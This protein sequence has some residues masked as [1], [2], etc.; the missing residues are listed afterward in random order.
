V[1]CGS[2]GNENPAPFRFCGRCGA[3][4]ADA[5]GP[6]SERRL[7]SVLFLDLVGFTAHAEQRDPED[8]R[9]LLEGYFATARTVIERLDGTL[10]KFIGDAVMALWGVPGAHDDDATRAVQAGLELV[11]AVQRYGPTVGIPSLSAR[12]GVATGE[13]ATTLGARDHGLVAGDIVN[14][15]SRLQA[16]AR[17]GTVLVDAATARASGRRLAF[18]AGGILSVRNRQQPVESYLAIGLG[19]DGAGGLLPEIPFVGR[20]GH[21]AALLAILEDCQ[22]SGT[23]RLATVVGGAGSGKTRLLAE[24]ERRTQGRVRWVAFRGDRHGERGPASEAAVR[25]SLAAAAGNGA[26]D[27]PMVVAIDDAQWV[28]PEAVPAILEWARSSTTPL[29]IVAAGRQEPG[30]AWGGERADLRVELKPIAAAELRGA[31]LE[32]APAIPRRLLR[33]IVDASAGLPLYA[34]EMVRMLADA[35]ILLPA[36]DRLAPGPSPPT[37]AMPESVHALLAAR[38]DGLEPAV[39][40]ALRD[41]AVLG[42]SFRDE[43]AWAISDLGPA[44]APLIDKLVAHGIVVREPGEATTRT[45]PGG[46]AEDTARYR[47]AD[48]LLRDVAYRSLGRRVRRL[49]HVAAARYYGSLDDAGV[50]GL[51]GEHALAAYRLDAAAPDAADLRD[52][53]FTALLEAAEDATRRGAPSQALTYLEEA[54]ELAEEADRGS[55]HERAATTAV[56]AA[57]A[58]AAETHSRAAIAWYRA[59]GD[60]QALARATSRL[61]SAL[62]LGYRVQP[63]ID[64]L[65]EVVDELLAAKD[66]EWDLELGWLGSRLADAYLVTERDQDALTWADRAIGSAE[67]LGDQALLASALDTKGSALASLGR[68]DEGAGMMR[69][70]IERAAT[71]GLA[72]E[73]S[74]ARQRLAVALLSDDPQAALDVARAGITEA[75]AQGVGDQLL[76][77]AG[78]ATEAALDAGAWTWAIE[79]IASFDDDDLALPDRIDFS[80]ASAV[81]AALR[82]DRL[83]AEQLNVLENVVRDA[84]DPLAVALLAS[85]QAQ[86]LLVLEDPGRALPLAREAVNGLRMAGYRTAAREGWIPMARAA[87]RI[88]DR[89]VLAEALAGLGGELGAGRWLAASRQA[90]AAGAAAL[91]GDRVSARTEYAA[92]EAGFR[93]LRLPFPLAQCLIDRSIVLDEVDGPAA[94]REAARVL[95]EADVVGP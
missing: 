51:A 93:E 12:A 28:G 67:T 53:A 66:V 63:A 57:D 18:E 52:A 59:S 20:D 85:R 92:A 75:R 43:A 23:S 88:G 71:A 42:T 14:T 2:C 50:V 41:V 39:A 36:G 29:L 35:R 76:R 62:L 10:E 61:G 21:L 16:N 47:F 30:V 22:R 54:L 40:T 81:I 25:D 13:V 65:A 72:A 86:V 48:T 90:L 89:Q 82:G 95:A 37:I 87:L 69:E 55:L 24:L 17:P 77:L 7:A 73:A 5:V 79:L 49:R 58:E 6:R 83:R 60:R 26:G 9:E 33:R 31:L 34:A 56:A 74:R 4:L 70:A 1:R 3:Q 15:A 78:T 94:A 27:V 46:V 11:E 19:S 80:G 8:V 32:L 44:V 68:L 84:A 45:A 38:I 64:A 91:D